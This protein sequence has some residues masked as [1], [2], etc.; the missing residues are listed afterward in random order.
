MWN[1]ATGAGVV[2][3]Q[4]DCNINE[5]SCKLIF[6]FS[7]RGLEEPLRILVARMSS[8]YSYPKLLGK[9]SPRSPSRSTTESDDTTPASSTI[10]SAEEIAGDTELLR[11]LHS[12]GYALEAEKNVRMEDISPILFNSTAEL[13]AACLDGIGAAQDLIHQLNRR[14]WKRGSNAIE[15]KEVA[16]SK[17][18]ARLRTSTDSFKTQDR[19]AIVVPFLPI[20]RA[21]DEDREMRKHLPLRSLIVASSFSAQ[22]AV[23]ATSIIELLDIIRKTT[24]KRRHSRLW[25]PSGLRVLG[26]IILRREKNTSIEMAFGEKTT[27]EVGEEEVEGKA[28]FS[29]FLFTIILDNC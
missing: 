27:I 2:R 1:S 22:L 20:L 29:M 7:T 6:V 10:N 13:R 3:T 24:E 17:A 25:A 21:A 28:T 4:G 11:Q 18:L 8:L 23:A 14:R 16:L 26:N 5:M 15:E 12:R 19:M 9:I